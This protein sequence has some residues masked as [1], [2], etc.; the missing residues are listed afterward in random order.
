MIDCNNVSK[1]F[2]SFSLKNITFNLPA[3]YICG[4]IGENGS[5]KTTLINILSGLYSYDGKIR[6][7]GRDY[8]NHEYDIK[9]DIGVVVHGDIFE[10]K[11]SLISNANYFGRFYKKYSKNLLE[12]YLERFNLNDKKRYKELSKGEKL[13]FALA[14]ALAHEPRL[15]LL[16]EPGANFDIEFR[17]E[18]NSLLREFIIDGTRSVILSTHIISD[19]ET[20]A[21]YIL[22]LKNGEQILFGDVETIREKY[23]MVSGEKYKIKLLKDRIIYLEE[24][25]IR[26]NAL[27]K[28][29]KQG[30]DKELK[31]WEPGIDELMYYIGKGKD[32]GTINQIL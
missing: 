24:G 5:G 18:F 6:I 31:V 25:R 12:N 26:C 11:E 13:K 21:D 20:F 9:Q 17:K 22:F 27:V 14:F 2:T 8:C 15:L 10:A 3:G 32:Y 7:S 28:H 1:R 29:D 16:D 19:V 4:L 23:R 30:Y